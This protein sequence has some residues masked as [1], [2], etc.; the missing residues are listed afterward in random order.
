MLYCIYGNLI[1]RSDSHSHDVIIDPT[2]RQTVTVTTTAGGQG[3]FIWPRG[4]D[5]KGLQRDAVCPVKGTVT[6]SF[7]DGLLSGPSE[8]MGGEVIDGD[9]L[10]FPVVQKLIPDA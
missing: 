4:I 5:D 1:N 2:C 10:F 7:D 6:L 9:E 8:N 3:D